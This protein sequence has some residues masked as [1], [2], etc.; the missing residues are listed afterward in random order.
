M[1]P[2]VGSVERHFKN[3]TDKN[4]FI[5]QTTESNLTDVLNVFIVAHY[6]L[7]IMG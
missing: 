5:M 6:R 1:P 2:R 3:G 7:Y 4:Y